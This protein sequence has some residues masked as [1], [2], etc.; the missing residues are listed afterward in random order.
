M[1]E[2]SKA[3]FEPLS[4]A[5]V[6]SMHVVWSSNANPSHP[7]ASHLSP[8]LPCPVLQDVPIQAAATLLKQVFKSM[9]SE[10]GRPGPARD[11]T[12]HCTHLSW[13]RHAWVFELSAHLLFTS[14]SH[15]PVTTGSNWCYGESAGCDYDHFM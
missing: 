10:W 13:T 1:Q 3:A 9:S 7:R 14:H 4:D 11:E 12:V 8:C 2:R 5:L 6:P 15:P